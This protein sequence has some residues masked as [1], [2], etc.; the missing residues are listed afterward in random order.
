MNQE[1]SSGL[2]I[3]Q[4]IEQCLM[5]PMIKQVFPPPDMHQFVASQPGQDLSDSFLHVAVPLRDLPTV[6]GVTTYHAPPWMERRGCK[7]VFLAGPPGAFVRVKIDQ[8]SEI[9]GSDQ[10]FLDP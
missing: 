8:R 2:K 4:P 3:R 6:G 5:G 7:T 9:F 10:L 1:T